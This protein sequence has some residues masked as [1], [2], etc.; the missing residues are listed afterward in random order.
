MLSRYVTPNSLWEKLT[1]RISE[2]DSSSGTSAATRHGTENEDVARRF[3]E[4]LMKTKVEE[5]GLWLHPE[6]TWLGASPDGLVGSDGLLEIKC[7]LYRVHDQVP[8]HYMAQVQGQIECCDRP[9]CDF[10]SWSA[11]QQ[12]LIRVYRSKT[13]WKW[14]HQM[15][16]N[17]WDC[18]QLGRSPR[19]HSK[20]SPMTPPPPVRTRILFCSRRPKVRCNAIST[21]TGRR[22]KRFRKKGSIFFPPGDFER[23]APS[24]FLCCIHRAETRRKVGSETPQPV[25]VS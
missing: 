19:S 16:K 17:F 3:Y 5:T 14:L 22:C 24:C 9:Y 21:S 13:Y 23:D 1:G 6:D 8:A 12:R 20:T 11:G 10:L 18:V 4:S 25:E 15:L 7:P 2:A